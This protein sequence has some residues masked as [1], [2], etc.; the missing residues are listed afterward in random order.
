MADDSVP[1]SPDNT[2]VQLAAEQARAALALSASDM[3]EFEWNVADDIFIVSPRM[4]RI[5]GIPVGAHP[6]QGGE[7]PLSF[8]HPDDVDALRSTIEESLNSR[9]RYQANYRMIRPSD[10]R[11]LWMESSAV[12]L[13]GPDGPLRKLIGVVR[14][15]SA[16]KAREDEREAL[17]AEL[18]H[19]VKN[20]LASVQSLAAQSAR[21][22]SSLD[23]FMKTFTGRIEA[24]ADA[25]IL[26]SR[27][28]WRG[29]SI[30]DIA[31]AELSGLAL[32]RARW[33]GPELLLSPRATNALALALHELATNAVKFGALSSDSGRVEVSWTVNG[34]GGFD[35]AWIERG[36]PPVEPPSRQGFG[37]LLLE[38][39]TGRELGGEA[40]VQYRRDGVRATLT[41]DHSAL[42]SSPEAPELTVANAPPGAAMATDGASGGAIEPHDVRGLRVLIVEDS[43]LLALELEAALA[44]A[45]AAIVGPAATVEEA[46]CLIT[47]GVDVALLDADLNGQSA[48]PVAAALTEARI[49]FILATSHDEELEDC[50]APVVRKPYNVHQITAALA[51]ATGAQTG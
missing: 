30:G 3:G 46:L 28:R 17:V 13:R 34:A 9:A 12:I 23:A 16:Q 8:A 41:A 38:R 50:A 47:D 4:A 48:A 44:E 37:A 42:S 25:H 7:Y 32:G 22:L 49:P 40:K 11:I 26:L 2:A 45:G 39:V 18:D 43:M 19:R 27:T 21:K 20:V 51:R 35:L 5:T 33:S 6:A 31:A 15:V 36:G 10:G 24:M 29:A 14:D 1:S